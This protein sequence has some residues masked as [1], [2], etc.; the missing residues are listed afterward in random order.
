MLMTSHTVTLLAL[1]FAKASLG[2]HHPSLPD[3]LNNIC[4][5]MY[6][7]VLPVDQ[8][9]A[10]ARLNNVEISGVN[11]TGLQENRGSGLVATVESSQEHSL[12]MTIPNDLV[13]SLENVWV[14]AK[15]DR[16]LQQI[17]DATGDY[18]RVSGREASF[19]Q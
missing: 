11:V 9:D 18:A 17:L 3:A 4:S 13:L 1:T 8:L 14:Y 2:L 16:H 19:D 5:I 15:A 7:E 12:L 6:R 10:W